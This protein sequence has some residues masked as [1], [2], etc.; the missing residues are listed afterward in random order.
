MTVIVG[1]KDKNGKITLGCDSAMTGYTQHEMNMSKIVYKT[2]KKGEKR[3]KIA[4]GICGHPGLQS[5]FE[6][7]FKIP[8]H[9]GNIS[10]P[11]YMNTVFE[12]EMRKQTKEANLVEVKNE[13]ARI[14]YSYIMIAY[15]GQLFKMDSRYFIGEYKDNYIATGSG[16]EHAYG[17]LY[18]TEKFDITSKERVKLAL[19]AAC[20]YIPSCAKPLKIREL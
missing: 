6:Y 14:V 11:R 19:E 3:N 7:T 20:K 5:F 16:E 8:E 12:K 9:K 17:S 10:V 18:S 13:T 2:V 15:Q 1:I 4:F